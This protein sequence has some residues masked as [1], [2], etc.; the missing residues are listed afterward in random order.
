VRRKRGAEARHVGIFLVKE[1]VGIVVVP[2]HDLLADPTGDRERDLA[3]ALAGGRGFEFSNTFFEICAAVVSLEGA[4]KTLGFSCALEPLL[5][6]SL[7][8]TVEVAPRGF[9]D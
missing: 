5:T 8:R 9:E 1:R 4:L 6:Q 7:T 2:V 3:V